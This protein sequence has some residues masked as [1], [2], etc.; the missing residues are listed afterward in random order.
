LP[1]STS[2]ATSGAVSRESGNHGPTYASRQRFS[3]RSRFSP[4]G[5]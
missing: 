2:A 5:S 3:V 4:A 1:S